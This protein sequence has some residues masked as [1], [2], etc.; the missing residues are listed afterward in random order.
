MALKGSIRVPSDKSISHRAV[1]FA[2]LAQ[3]SSRLRDLLPSDDVLS[4][5]AAVDQL[6]AKVERS[7]GDNGIDAVVTGFGGQPV[8]GRQLQLDCGNS[9]TTTR[10]LM[11]LVCGL[12]VDVVLFG[13]ESLSGRPM[14]RVIEPL[15]AMG[16]RIESESGTL[17]AHVLPAPGPLTAAHYDSPKASAQVKSA[18]LL[19]G[20]QASGTTSVTEPAKSRDHTE[21]LLPA[22]GVPVEVDGLTVSVTGPAQLRAHDMSAPGDPSSAAFLAVIAAVLEDSELLIRNV[23]LNPTRTGA[24]AVLQRMGADLTYENERLEGAE[25]VG[26][27]RVTW[28]PQLTGTVVTAEE[29]PTLVDEVPVLAIAAAAAQGE[30]VFQ[31]AGELRV[32]ESD[33]F[34]AVV[35]GLA[36][37]GVR[38][39]GEGDDLHI[40]GTGEPLYLLGDALAEDGGLELPTYHDHRLAMTWY[41][42]GLAT[43]APVLLDDAAC[44]SVSWPSFF[45]DVEGLL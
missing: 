32:K 36:A 22:F 26:D 38:A 20:L 42:M 40:Q 6:G 12:G 23:A 33:R 21:R 25:P 39:W 3:G 2:A 44:V 11:G 31:G 5:L 4:S 9:G 17:P 8:R 37:F 19:A 35:E 18:V 45:A 16:A 13:D 10:L 41:L 27:V 14:R 34:A 29:I 15:S 30:T 7:Q 28:G 1:L 43:E 24:F